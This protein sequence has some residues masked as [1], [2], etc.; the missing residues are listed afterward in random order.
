M[1]AIVIQLEQGK[2]NV[3]RFKRK[4]GA[5]FGGGEKR[6]TMKEV[7]AMETNRVML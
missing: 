2:N 4:E 5:L 6:G 3:I 1:W 7:E